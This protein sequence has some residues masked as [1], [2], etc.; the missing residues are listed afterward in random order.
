MSKTV[1][2]K[3]ILCFAASGLLWGCEGWRPHSKAREGQAQN[4]LTSFRQLDFDG[5]VAGQR[6][7]WNALMDADRKARLEKAL[8]DADQFLLELVRAS[9]LGVVL[10]GQKKKPKTQ[11]KLKTLIGKDW[12]SRVQRRSDGNLPTFP[13]T[14]DQKVIGHYSALKQTF[15][16]FIGASGAVEKEASLFE[17][18]LARS[19]GACPLPY[20]ELKQAW[21]DAQNGTGTFEKNAIKKA[22]AIGLPNIL[23]GPFAKVS[24]KPKYQITTE[25]KKFLKQCIYRDVVLALILDEQTHPIFDGKI[26]TDIKK[27]RSARKKEQEQAKAIAEAKKRYRTA[28]KELKEAQAAPKNASE[29]IAELAKIAAEKLQTLADGGGVFGAIEEASERFAILSRIVAALSSSGDQGGD[30]GAVSQGDAAVAI[31]ARLPGLA[32]KVQAVALAADAPPLFSLLIAKDAAEVRLFRARRKLARHL[33]MIALLQAR[34]ALR[35]GQGA[36]LQTAIDSRK[37]LERRVAVI[38][39]QGQA[40]AASTIDAEIRRVGGHRMIDATEAALLQYR[41]TIGR[42]VEALSAYYAGGI[43]LEQ[44]LAL[45]QALGVGVIAGFQGT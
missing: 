14:K 21:A 13:M 8:A 32:D 31:A 24:G 28:A 34:F 44:I 27:L 7:N 45:F 19:P 9:D 35:L 4:A 10:N 40:I 18:R 37:P 29:E 2:A 1:A 25:Y 41:S 23:T 43:K 5:Y 39:A 15:D 33:E 20:D 22:E 38:Q 17:A 30:A 16:H 6:A 42:P 11:Q 12:L 36:Y 3:W 26:S